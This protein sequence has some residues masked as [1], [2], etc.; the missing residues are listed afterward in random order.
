M[1]SYTRNV[2]MVSRKLISIHAGNYH[3]FKTEVVV[4]EQEV[5]PPSFL[6]NVGVMFDHKVPLWTGTQVW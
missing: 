5:S 4:D 6:T 3:I 2:C 1:Y